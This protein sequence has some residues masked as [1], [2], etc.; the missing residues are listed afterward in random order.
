MTT[1]AWD[2]KRLAADSQ[3]TTSSGVRDGYRTKILR[4]GAV[5]AGAAGPVGSIKAFTD[6]VQ[7][8]LVGDI[9]AMHPDTEALL[10]APGHVLSL[11]DGGRLVPMNVNVTAIG[12]G[13][14]MAIGAME[15][16]AS[17]RK[18]IEIAARRDVWTGG[19]ITVLR[20]K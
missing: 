14:K 8:G 6:W 11:E 12:S 1:I 3:I 18:A 20:H 16:G 9:P 13:A 4:R 17:A 10:I 7:G 15:A 2:G 5:I 19:A